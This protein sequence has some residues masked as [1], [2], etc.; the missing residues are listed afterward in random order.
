LSPSFK[1]L[2]P[3]KAFL[4]VQRAQQTSHANGVTD[5]NVVPPPQASTIGARSVGGERLIRKDLAGGQTAVYE[6]CRSDK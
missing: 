1:T 3:R 2:A 4:A 5:T 6:Q